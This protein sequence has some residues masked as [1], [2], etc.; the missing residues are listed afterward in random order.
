MR[1]DLGSETAQNAIP[2]LLGG[3][4]QFLCSSED[5]ESLR[6]IP[7]EPVWR[8]AGV[9]HGIEWLSMMNVRFGDDSSTR[10]CHARAM[11]ITASETGVLRRASRFDSAEF[12]AHSRDPATGRRRRE[13]HRRS[14]FVDLC[15]SLFFE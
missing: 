9:E 13:P 15:I 5:F 3:L 11:R 1:A 14:R 8:G 6:R 12:C 2:K 7:I 10:K 4:A